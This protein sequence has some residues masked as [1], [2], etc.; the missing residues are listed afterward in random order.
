MA[1]ERITLEPSIDEAFYRRYAPAIFAY[2]LRHI[3]SRQDAEDLLLDIFLVV[4]EKEPALRLDEQRLQGYMR[5]VARNKVA[6]YY[7][8]IHRHPLVPLEDVEET[9]YE[10]EEL[11]PERVV[12]DQERYTQLYRAVNELPELHQRILQLRF[13]HGLRCAEIATAISKSESAVRMILYRTLKLLRTSHA[14]Y[15]EIAD[16]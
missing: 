14:Q 8:R 2:L 13:S 12:L 1:Q 16:E 3:N 6:D 7:R 11:A 9:I 15:K 10:S 5:T 4:L